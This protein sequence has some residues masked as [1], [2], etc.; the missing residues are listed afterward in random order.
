MLFY[1]LLTSLFAIFTLSTS[2]KRDNQV[3][4]PE[5]DSPWYITGISIYQPVANTNSSAFIE[6]TIADFNHQ[7]EAA[8]QCQYST[9][10]HVPIPVTPGEGYYSCTNSVFG[11]R[12]DGMSLYIIRDYSYPFITYVQ[13]MTCRCCRLTDLW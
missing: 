4:I 13:Y 6:F 7:L 12:Y 5:E 11:F 8:S 1:I 3:K 2:L 10:A 9:T